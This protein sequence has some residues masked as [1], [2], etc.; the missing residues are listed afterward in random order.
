MARYY[1]I[2]HDGAQ[3]VRDDEGSPLTAWTLRCRQPLARRQRLKQVDWQWSTPVM[4]SPRL[5]T[6]TTSG[7]APQKLRWSVDAGVNSPQT[8][9]LNF[10]K[11]SAVASRFGGGRE[12]RHANVA[13]A[14][15]DG[16]KGMG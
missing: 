6:S 5:E 16:Q 1:F 4:W 8:C 2:I 9:R 15:P 3:S 12:D 11:L 13:D 10:L 7:S 14:A